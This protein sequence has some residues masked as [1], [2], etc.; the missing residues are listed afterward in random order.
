MRGVIGPEQLAAAPSLQPKRQPEVRIPGTSKRGR[1]PFAAGGVATPP[2]DDLP[3]C[4]P[5]GLGDVPVD[6]PALRF[7]DG[8][9]A[10]PRAHNEDFISQPLQTGRRV[11]EP[12]VSVPLI[13][14]TGI[15]PSFPNMTHPRPMPLSPTTRSSLSA[16]VAISASSVRLPSGT[17]HL[18]RSTPRCLLVVGAGNISNELLSLFNEH[19]VAISLPSRKLASSELGPDRLVIDDER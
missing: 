11:A 15:L 4:P 2:T 13:I 12:L 16:S 9:T 18:L 1:G 7:N 8:R 3:R 5:T 6:G 14:H 10:T 19:P 17:R